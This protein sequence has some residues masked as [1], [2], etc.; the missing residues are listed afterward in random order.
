[1]EESETNPKYITV[2]DQQGVNEEFHEAFQKINR[3][4]DVDDSSEAIEEFLD[5]DDD[6]NSKVLT[7]EESNKVKGEIPL[8]EL[9]Y[10]LFMKMKESSAPGI[11]GFTINWLRKFWSSLKLVIPN[12]INE[13]YRDGAITTNLLNYYFCIYYI[14]GITHFHV[15]CA[16][17]ICGIILVK[18][19]I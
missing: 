2:M 5:S 17:Y 9:Q 8:D 4:R 3:K 14:S 7:E 19:N 12:T 15:K 1:M 11:N 10:I 16:N 13:L 6:L 18:D